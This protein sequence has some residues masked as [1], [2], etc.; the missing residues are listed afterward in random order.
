MGVEPD[1]ANAAFVEQLPAWV[2]IGLP[3]DDPHAAA[4]GEPVQGGVVGIKPAVKPVEPA[5]QPVGKLVFK[6]AAGYLPD[7]GA[8]VPVFEFDIVGVG[9]VHIARENDEIFGSTTV[10]ENI[11]DDIG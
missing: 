9:V 4:F 3:R 2:I 1:P 5:Q 6:A 10:P 7:I 8:I 11:E